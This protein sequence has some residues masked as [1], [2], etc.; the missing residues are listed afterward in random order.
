MKLLIV[1]SPGKV[2]KIQTFLGEEFKVMASVGHVRDLPQKEIGISA[3]EFK[4]QYVPTD[5]GKEVLAKLDS[6]AK[7]ADDVYLATDPDR[8]GEAIAWHLAVALKLKNPKRVTYTEITEKAVKEAVAASRS[9]DMNLVRAQ[10]GRRVLD[11]LV[12]YLVSPA[13]SNAIGG[14]VSAGRVQSPALRMVVDRENNIRNFNST[15]H[16]GVEFTFE[17]VDN[18]TNGWKA[19][20]NSKDWLEA[21][22]E[23]YL[24]KSRAEAIAGLRTFTVASYQETESRQS[25]PAPFTTSS[26][27]QAASNSLKISPKY[28]MELAQKLYEAGA[29]TYMRTDSPN[30][31]EEAIAEI[32]GIASDNDWAVPPKPRTWKSKDGAQE[33]HEAIRPTHFKEAEAGSND[34]E[35]ALYALIRTRALASQLDDA[36]YAV[37]AAV[38]E[39]DFEGKKVI[40]EARGRRLLTPGWRAILAGDQT[41]DDQQDNEPDNCLPKLRTD[42]QSLAVDGQVLTKKTKPPARFSEAT[43]IRDLEKMGIGRPSTYAAIIENITSRGYVQTEK[44]QLVPT[45]IGNRII[46]ALDGK[47]GFLDFTFT[48]NLEA[49]LDDVAAGAA[50]YLQT[51]SGLYD[52]LIIEVNGFVKANGHACP[53]CGRMLRHMVKAGKYDFWSCSGYPDHCQSSF[54]NSGG[55]PGERQE[56]KTATPL[57]EF[58]CSDCGKP[59]RHMVKE[60]DSGYN[61][62]S[63]SGYPSC[64]ASYKDDDG[65]PGAKNEPK[66]PASNHKCPKCK[67]PLVRRT[68]TSKASGKDYDFFGCTD[69]TCNATYPVKGEKPDFEAKRK[70]AKK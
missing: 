49:R 30:L 50:D 58:M 28:T 11:R 35:Q 26:L 2:K 3:P 37:T 44:R 17:A 7:Q 20:W 52:I 57:S 41:D 61:F 40:L 22:Q 48:R 33:A 6:A 31:S 59:L 8:E 45:E 36:L 51:V 23:Y 60:G 9:I 15:T 55:K 54:K 21:D 69:R 66:A 56:K 13:L 12:G 70:S 27:Q 46:S 62:W 65:Q 42:G 63:C 24:D 32:R 5:R 16:F 10:E 67:K 19:A 68:G 64:K 25:P 53:D 14:Q 39:A 43:L 29:I 1:E 18:A 4:P 47:F 34:D 38:L